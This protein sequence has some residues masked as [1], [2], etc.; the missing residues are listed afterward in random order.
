MF[1]L[2]NMARGYFRGNKVVKDFVSKNPQYEGLEKELLILHNEL[3]VEYDNH[4]FCKGLETVGNALYDKFEG[5]TM[6]DLIKYS[7]DVLSAETEEEVPIKASKSNKEIEFEKSLH[8]YLDAMEYHEKKHQVAE[9]DRLS[10]ADKVKLHDIYFDDSKQSSSLFLPEFAYSKSQVA[11]LE[12]LK[13]CVDKEEDI[14]LLPDSVVDTYKHVLH[15]SYLDMPSSYSDLRIS[16]AGKKFEFLFD[17]ASAHRVEKDGKKFVELRFYPGSVRLED[18]K[19]FSMMGLKNYIE[20]KEFIQEVCD[21]EKERENG[22]KNEVEETRSLEKEANTVGKFKFERKTALL[23]SNKK[24]NSKESDKT[25][26]F[27]K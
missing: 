22:V 26:D 10:D 9:S 24:G 27:E 20:F 4:Y 7:K 1:R 14:V 23:E 5:T 17:S 3:L 8:W 13:E 2:V 21:K 12:K 15:D 19:P 25:Q 6:K 16:I 18:E 11:K